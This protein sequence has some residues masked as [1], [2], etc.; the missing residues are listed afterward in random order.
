V[1]QNSLLL[2]WVYC[3]LSFNFTHCYNKRI[4]KKTKTIVEK[5]WDWEL[6]LNVSCEILQE[7]IGCR[8][9]LNMSTK[10]SSMIH[11][12]SGL[13]TKYCV[14]ILELSGWK[15]FSTLQTINKI[16]VTKLTCG[17]GAKNFHTNL[18]HWGNLI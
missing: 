4:R 5:C 1:L 18:H 14:Y 12:L 8:H 2:I 16:N 11:E 3:W 6:S 10:L 15:K 9:A 7:F 17:C 13:G